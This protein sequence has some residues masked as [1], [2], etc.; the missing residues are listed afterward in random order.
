MSPLFHRWM[1]GSCLSCSVAENLGLGL[2]E[3]LSGMI[4]RRA[5]IFHI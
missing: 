5:D 1:D 2:G 4:G 3:D